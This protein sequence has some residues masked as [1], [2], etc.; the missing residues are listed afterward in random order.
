[1]G[2]A[3]Q[4][5]ADAR[6]SIAICERSHNLLDTSASQ[7]A[8]AR[9]LV[10]EKRFDEAKAAADIT[11]RLA[12]RSEA[13][14][15]WIDA[16][17]ALSLALYGS[18]PRDVEAALGAA[19]K[20]LERARQLGLFGLAYEAQLAAGEIAAGGRRPAARAQLRALA[21]EADAHGFGLVARKART[22]IAL[23]R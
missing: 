15:E 16:Q 6:E 12:A 19:H 21:H 1:E 18:P 2:K 23:A 9:V 11:L 3:E 17:I 4:A 14:P 20:A 7:A 22:A 13:M 10:V 5:E 8:L